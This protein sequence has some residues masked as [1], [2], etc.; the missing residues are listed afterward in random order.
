MAAGW[1]RTTG[2]VVGAAGLVAVPIVLTAIPIV[3]IAWLLDV[4]VGLAFL[5]AAIVG[6]LLSAA[7]GPTLVHRRI[8]RLPNADLDE[9]PAAF[10]E[11]RVDELAD[12]VGVDAPE[13]TVVRSDAANVAVTE[14]YRGSQIVASTR[15]LSLPAA[16]RDAALRH[17]LVRL[18]RREALFTTALLPALL[19]VETV[20]L[21]ATLLVGRRSDRSPA[22]RR[23]NRIHG[24]EPDRE[25]IPT[26]VY[27]VA[28]ILLWVVLF[29]AWIP[30]A[31]GDRLFVAGQRRAADAEVAGVGET[32]RDGLANAVAFAGEAA[33][34][35]DWPPLLDRL[36]LVSMAD[37]ETGRVRGASRQEAR[38]RLARLR[39]K[40][41]VHPP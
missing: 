12:E 34:A 33:G 22:D 28:G 3:P 35:A 18:R 4:G 6:V 39:S 5:A 16:D 40:V 30:A 14:G 15:L 38:V 27:A 1:T 36:S 9:R 41:R 8:R 21:L 37:D 20:A 2:T 17:A 32:E 25:R 10:I 26:P 19:V 11:Y 31:V 24:Y 13:I 29:P 7:F 23:V